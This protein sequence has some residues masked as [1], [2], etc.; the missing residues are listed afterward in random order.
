MKIGDKRDFRGFTFVEVAIT[1]FLLVVAFMGL[2]SVTVMVV[3]GN[4]ISKMST[5]ASA[6]ASAKLEDL[7]SMSFT[8]ANLA[9]GS[10]ADTENPL[11]GFYTRSWNVTDFMD[12]SGT[13][14]SYKTIS[15]TVTWNGQNRSRS[16]SLSTLKT[17]QN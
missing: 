12:A 13:S 10:H 6:I 9:A 11:Q 5:T 8:N 3:N 16:M 1:I 14:V 7:K 4:A 15:L 2:A 17:N